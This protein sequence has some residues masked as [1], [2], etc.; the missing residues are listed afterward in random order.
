[1]CS[2]IAIQ[3]IDY[4]NLLVSFGISKLPATIVTDKNSAIHVIKNSR[5]RAKL[6]RHFRDFFWVS[7]RCENDGLAVP[8]IEFLNRIRLD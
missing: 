3:V 8:H 1:M 7:E 4:R 6:T 2:D 5:T